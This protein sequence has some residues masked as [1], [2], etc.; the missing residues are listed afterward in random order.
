MGPALLHHPA[1]QSLV[2]PVLL[3]VLGMGLVG[4]LRPRWAAFGVLPALLLSLALLP[5][6]HWPA[7]AAAEKL[8]WVVALSAV[9]AG[10]MAA[11]LGP[12]GRCRP[13]LPWLLPLLLWGAVSLW[14][15]GGRAP[16][17]IQV[18]AAAG[19]AAVLVLLGWALRAGP[20]HA[21]HLGRAPGAGA[22]ACLALAG[23]ALAGLAVL[24][25][26][27]LLAQ[28]AALLASVTAVL[29][30]GLWLRPVAAP[31]GWPVLLPLALGWGLVALAVAWQAQGS[32]SAPPDDDPYY[33]AYP[34]P[35]PR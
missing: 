6:Y 15:V 26:S 1:M 28:L 23:F 31:A 32:T 17:L 13:V 20:G 14:V 21:G 18:A 34:E 27:L 5:G 10:V 3:A 9:G 8:P 7:A 4:L 16:V 24:V 25:G 19:G 2:V 12:A 30:L 33:P 22:A 35:A 11:W 29:A